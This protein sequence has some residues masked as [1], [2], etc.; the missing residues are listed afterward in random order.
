MRPSF[1]SFGI[2]A[3]ASIVASLTPY[4]AMQAFKVYDAGDV[5]IAAALF[6]LLWIGPGVVLG[7]AAYTRDRARVWGALSGIP[8]LLLFFVGG[9][10]FEAQQ[11]LALDQRQFLPAQNQHEIVAIENSVLSEHEGFEACRDMCEQILFKSRYVPAVSDRK[12]QAWRVYRLAHGQACVDA[13]FVSRLYGDSCIVMA[14]QRAIP[15]AL[16]VRENYEQ[17]QSEIRRSL[18]YRST[19]YEFLERTD[20]QDSLLGRWVTSEVPPAS[21]WVYMWGLREFR[22]GDPIDPQAFYAEALGIPM[23]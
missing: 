9:I 15:N 18:P 8:L 11:I 12:G 3:V 1:W 10:L 17:D 22:V 6:L 7:T 19:V 21:D 4:W 20:G 14:Y 5:F 2:Y 13:A 23:Q 16:V